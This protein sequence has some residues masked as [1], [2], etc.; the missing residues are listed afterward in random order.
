MPSSPLSWARL[1]AVMTPFLLLGGALVS[2]YMGGLYPCEMCMWQR[3]PH[4]T[5]ILLALI[6]IALRGQ[7]RASAFVTAL[8]A[9]AIAVSGAIGVFHA[10]VEYKWWEGFTACTTTVGSGG[11][12][13]LSQIMAAPLTRCDTAPWTLLNISLA[14]Y[15]ALFSLGGALIVALLLRRARTKA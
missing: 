15:N 7:P 11:G 1:V 8:C 5:A 13:A 12:D 9:L 4:V 2:Q 10:G 6:A 3:W 14:G